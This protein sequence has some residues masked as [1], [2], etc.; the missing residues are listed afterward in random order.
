MVEHPVTGDEII[1]RKTL[2]RDYIVPG[3]WRATPSTPVELHHERDPR[4]IM[5]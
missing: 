3:D 1:L 5:R 2:Q 4:W